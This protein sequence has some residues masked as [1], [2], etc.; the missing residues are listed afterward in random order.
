M[1]VKTTSNVCRMYHRSASSEYIK[2][3]ESL[4]HLICH[5]AVLLTYILT[6]RTPQNADA[7]PTSHDKMTNA[8]VELSTKNLVDDQQ[9]M[10]RLIH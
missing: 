6:Y 1:H 5:S 9:I 4:H 8:T 10:H 7:V 2:P 3:R